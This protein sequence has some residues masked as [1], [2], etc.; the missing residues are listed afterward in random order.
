[1]RNFV[2]LLSLFFFLNACSQTKTGIR[3]TYA[4][5]QVSFPGN[6]PVDDN[7]NPMKGADTLRFVYIETSGRQAPTISS[8]QYN[9]TTY[10]ASVFPAEKVPVTAGT[11]KGSDQKIIIK[12]AAGN[13]LWRIELTPAGR[14][15]SLQKSMIIKG[16]VNGKPF[17]TTIKKEVELEPE[18]HA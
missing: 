9:N 13:S 7:G 6:I 14:T 17:T 11:K 1:M 15:K 16:A 18:I 8:A 2:L 4:F 10:S 3:K 5:F 12:P